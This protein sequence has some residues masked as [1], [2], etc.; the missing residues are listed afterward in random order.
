VWR[1][2]FATPVGRFGWRPA[3]LCFALGPRCT[4]FLLWSPVSRT[5][6]LWFGELPA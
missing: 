4:R 5:A 1:V 6:A 2:C 3:R